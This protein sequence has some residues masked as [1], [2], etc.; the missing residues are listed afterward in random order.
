MLRAL[1]L[2]MLAVAVAACGPSSAQF[3]GLKQGM[4][5]AE[6]VALLG[7]PSSRYPALEGKDGPARVERWQWGDSLSS[8]ATSAAFS[9][10]DAPDNVWVVYFGPDERVARWRPAG[11]AR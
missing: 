9:D 7:E 4:T 2:V 3:S 1:A 6:V 11:W 10:Q 8:L 5:K